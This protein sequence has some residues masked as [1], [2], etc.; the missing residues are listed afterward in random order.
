MTG[1]WGRGSTLA[2]VAVL[3]VAVR[4]RFLD[5]QSGDYRTFLS[6]WYAFI[7]TN[8]HF[9]ALHDDSFSNYNTPY[10]VLLALTSYLPIPPI[11]AIK[12]LSIL[13]DLALAG[14]AAAIV[15]RLRPGARWAPVAAFGVVLLLPTVVMNSGV[16]GQCD[17]L[18]AAA[19]LACVLC[20]LEDALGPRPHGSG[21]RSASSC[22]RCSCCPRSSRW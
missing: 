20:L 13:G 21:L 19:S 14:V 5:F 17:S 15:L 22:R 7:S 12:T 10:L 3:G 16:W 1:R 11:V 9:A 6:R 4:W 18:Y 2:A 8:G